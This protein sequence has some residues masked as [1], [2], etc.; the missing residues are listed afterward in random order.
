MR[1]HQNNL[2]VLHLSHQGVWSRIRWGVWHIA[3]LAPGSFSSFSASSFLL[4]STVTT[5]ANA[6]ADVPPQ[7]V[8]FCRRSATS[9]QEQVKGLLDCVLFSKM[10]SFTPH[11]QLRAFASFIWRKD[12]LPHG[13]FKD[14]SIFAW[15][16]RFL[17]RG[18]QYCCWSVLNNFQT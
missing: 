10:F 3:S 17:G 7:Q 9:H 18:F 12:G 4:N 5:T 16:G 6:A 11:G 1:T 8:K 13:Q 2:S 15:G 14:Q